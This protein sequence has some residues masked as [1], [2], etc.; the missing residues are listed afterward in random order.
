MLPILI[1]DITWL[2][3]KSSTFSYTKY[4][5]DATQKVKILQ[6][7]LRSWT[8]DINVFKEEHASREAKFNKR[9]I[10]KFTLQ[11]KYP[12]HEHVMHTTENNDA[13]RS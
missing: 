5:S 13:W 7:C 8:V 6:Y 3:S 10:S 12:I 4:K 2:V 1:Y 11:T 9:G